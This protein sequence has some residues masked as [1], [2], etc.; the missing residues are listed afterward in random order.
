MVSL[1]LG[2]VFVIEFMDQ[3]IKTTDDIE[4]KLKLRVLATIPDYDMT[5]EAID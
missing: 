3:T 5:E 2:L 4:N 1:V